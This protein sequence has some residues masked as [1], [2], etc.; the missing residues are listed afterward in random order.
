V[1]EL[2]LHRLDAGALPDQQRCGR[3]PQV[4][5]AQRRRQPDRPDGQLK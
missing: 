2:L 4:V 5:E 1:P 3:V